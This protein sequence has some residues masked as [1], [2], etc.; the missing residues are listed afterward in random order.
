M[1][2]TLQSQAAQAIREHT[3]QLLREEVIGGDSL[4]AAVECIMLEV[5]D[6]PVLM[7]R[8]E[9][10][11]DAAEVVGRT[12][13]GDYLVRWKTLEPRVVSPKGLRIMR[14]RYLLTLNAERRPRMEAWL[15]RVR[16][17]EPAP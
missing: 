17:E 1:S 11:E 8:G 7:Y 5:A 3:D 13:G 16:G 15:R 9:R 4:F 10:L 6:S 14:A 2:D 12:R